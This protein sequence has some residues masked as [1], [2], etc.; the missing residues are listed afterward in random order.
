MRLDQ[1]ATN[2]NGAGRRP[3]NQND[4]F[5]LLEVLIAVSI[6]AIG[7]LAIA[8]MQTSSI[9]VNSTA[10]QITSRMTWAQDKLEQISALPYNNPWL[11]GVDS[12]TPDSAGNLHQETTGDGYTIAWDIIDD[13]PMT[14][15]KR[16]TV[17]VTGRGKTTQLVGIKSNLF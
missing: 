13:N 14:G 3:L 17:T 4:G 11:D 5:T 6:F 9:R 16:I 12:S 8:T 10:G 15:T 7:L 2:P 1:T